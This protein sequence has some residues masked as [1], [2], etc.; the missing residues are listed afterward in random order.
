MNT[1]LGPYPKYKDSALSWIGKIPSHWIEKRAKY[2]F[3]EVDE[4]STTGEEQ[5][6][7]VSHK[8]GVTPRKSN[9]T[10]FKAESNVGH[11]ICRVHDLA[12]NTLWAWMSALGVSRY[13]GLVSPAYGVYRQ[14][15]PDNFHPQFVDHLLRVPAY[16]AEYRCL[17]T[18]ITSSRLRLY[19]IDFLRIP[20]LQPPRHEQEAIARY[21]NANAT[22]V[23]QFI[24][25]RLKL[26]ET[27]TEQKL[28]MVS[29]A[30]TR[31]LNSNSP[32]KPSG[33]DWLGEIP[34][35]WNVMRCKYLFREIDERSES[36]NET[37]LSMSQ[38]F[39][40]IP[41]D[42]TDGK[43][44]RSESYAGGKLCQPNDLVLNRL[45]AHLGVFAKST[46]R[47]VVSPDYTVLRPNDP[48]DS[49]YYERLF[50]TPACIAELRRSTKG[51]VEGFWR[52]Y[53]DDFYNLFVPVPTK[54][55]RQQIL[56]WLSIATLEFDKAIDVAFREVELM[57]EYRNRLIADVVCG[58][59]NVQTMEY[60]SD[61][62]QI[63][64]LAEADDDLF[65]EEELDEE[66]V[67]EDD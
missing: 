5:L 32:M 52:L 28:A 20:L 57:R 67:Y 34:S 1:K 62:L 40:L 2:F 41:S 58:A 9:V 25:N 33:V 18:G 64:E 53:T 37:H 24:R 8:T 44:L 6:M 43:H 36:G 16:A 46:R 27:L 63:D 29:Q 14:I 66:E 61:I 13:H 17:S 19:P 11:K 21:L 60:S 55:D 51:I 47:G 10:M 3:K 65:D 35:H 39:G 30:V 26:I 22:L 7:S 4:R 23:R 49:S 56:E 12:I 48:D 54:S 42:E 59:L 50:K 45:K 15:D 38:R 31:G